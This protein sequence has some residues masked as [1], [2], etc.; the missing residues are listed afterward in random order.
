[1][2]KKFFIWLGVGAIIGIASISFIE[3]N[4]KSSKKNPKKILFVGDSITSD[5]TYSYPA[6]I[7]KL[8]PDLT[9]DVLAKSGMT[10]KWMLEN[11]PSKI[12]NGYDRIYI[13]GGVNDA[14]NTGIAYSTTLSN[15][16]KMV[17]MAKDNGAESYVILGYE[18]TPFMDY[19]K[20]PPTKYVKTKEAYI[21][22]IKRYI[23]L[24][25]VLEGVKGAE[26]VKRFDLGTN[27]SDGT[28]P[29]GTGQKI[30]ANDIIKTF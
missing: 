26:I 4:K 16:Q 12:K 18:P 24:Q 21:P 7:K 19:K 22:L 17:D 15:V 10:T 25:R 14:F 1:M 3:R 27:T 20:M 8:R 30:I 9:I 11:L 2:D 13:Y 6:I 29:S 5:A 23:E 28:H